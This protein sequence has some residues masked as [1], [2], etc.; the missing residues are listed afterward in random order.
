MIL[1]YAL[2]LI[3]LYMVE[4]SEKAKHIIKPIFYAA[5]IILL[6]IFSGSGIKDFVYLE[7]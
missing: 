5:T 6:V 7:F 1:M 4:L 2:P 3:L